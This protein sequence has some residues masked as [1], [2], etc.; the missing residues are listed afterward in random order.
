MMFS[1]ISKMQSA[2]HIF[3]NNA[4]INVKPEGGRP[5]ICGGFDKL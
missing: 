1:E 3:D 5:G 2:M 4:G